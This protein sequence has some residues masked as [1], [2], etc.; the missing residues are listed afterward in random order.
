MKIFR[1]DIWAGLRIIFR[2]DHRAYRRMGVYDFPQRHLLRRLLVSLGWLITGLPGIRTR[3][4]RMIKTQMVRPYA[5]I[6]AAAGP[7]EAEQPV[8]AAA[9]A[10]AARAV[11]TVSA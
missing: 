9:D 5:R 7:L 3:F 2:A 4:P 8:P 1:D 10:P 11:Q 6:L